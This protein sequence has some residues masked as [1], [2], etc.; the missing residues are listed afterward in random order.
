MQVSLGGVA[1]LIAALAFALL[2]LRLGSLIGKAGG[3][4]DEARTGVRG[5]SEQS[6]PLLSQV[7]DTV[8]STNQQIVRVDAITSNVAS[9]A[10]N[11]NALV[12]LFAATVGSPLV[13]VAAFG[14]VV[15]HAASGGPSQSRL[16]RRSVRTFRDGMAER[17]ADLRQAYGIENAGSNAGD[18]A[19]STAAVDANRTQQ[20]L[21]DP[22]GALARSDAD[23]AS[24]ARRA[25]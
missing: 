23:L 24:S 19:A 25:R 18:A 1:G 12:S 21:A 20:L 9:A 14:Y 17:E 2:V 7:T 10:S 16:R 11:V 13:K 22:A 8:A 3:I 4:L 5:L 15:R 6:V